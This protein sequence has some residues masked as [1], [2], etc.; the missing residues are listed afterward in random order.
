MTPAFCEEDIHRLV[1][2]RKVV[3]EGFKDSRETGAHAVTG[4]VRVLNSDYQK[5]VIVRYTLNNWKTSLD[6]L[7]EWEGSIGASKENVTDMDRFRF[8]IP[9]PS[10]DWS[11]C[12]E[13]AVRYDVAGRTFWDSNQKEN[14]SIVVGR[15]STFAGRF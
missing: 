13:F 4:T 6:L 12:V 7:A 14:H 8:M 15:R 1:Q 10:K 9:L 11:G 3:V 2:E 5:H